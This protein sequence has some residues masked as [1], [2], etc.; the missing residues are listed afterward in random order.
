MA[1]PAMFSINAQNARI[2]KSAK[3]ISELPQFENSNLFSFEAIITND[4]P[5]KF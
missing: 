3:A 1:Q 4:F 5:R 2:S